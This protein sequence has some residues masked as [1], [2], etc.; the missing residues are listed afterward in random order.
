ME[1][2]QSLLIG[3]IILCALFAFLRII[4]RGF[5]GG[6]DH[7]NNNDRNNNNRSNN[8]RRG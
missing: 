4:T 6:D 5:G 3:M 7:N 8:N 1:H 2:T